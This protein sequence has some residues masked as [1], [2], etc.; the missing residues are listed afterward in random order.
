MYHGRRWCTFGA[1]LVGWLSTNGHAAGPY[2]V[3]DA[4]IGDVGQCHVESWVSAADNGD[5]IVLTQPACV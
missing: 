3:D 2:A 1:C 4:T 5:I